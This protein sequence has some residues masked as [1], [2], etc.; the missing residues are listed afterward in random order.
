MNF[1]DNQPIVIRY[2]FYTTCKPQFSVE[3]S[4]MLS[5]AICGKNLCSL[6]QSYL[7]VSSTL[8]FS[9][10]SCLFV[11][12]TSLSFFFLQ[13]SN[14]L[15]WIFEK[16]VI[17]MVAYFLLSILNSMAQKYHK[18]LCKSQHKKNIHQNDFVQQATCLTSHIYSSLS[19]NIF[20]FLIDVSGDCLS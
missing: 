13:E 2:L 5:S 18:R 12:S 11:F 16:V 8:E 7:L 9:D 17:V 20:C 4:T 14:L 1:C 3:L 6:L 15:S 10:C 19:V